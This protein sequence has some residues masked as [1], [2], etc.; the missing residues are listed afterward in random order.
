MDLFGDVLFEEESNN[1]F[2]FKTIEQAI[3]YYYI[4]PQFRISVLNPDESI[5][6]IIPNEDIPVDGINYTEEYQNGQRRNLTLKLLNDKG[7]YNPSING[8]WLT[9]KFKYDIGLRV[10]NKIL[11]FPKGTYV[12]GNVS[13]D[14]NEG[15][16]IVTLTLKDKYAIFEGKMGTLEDPYEVEVGSNIYDAVKGVM[17]FNAGNGHIFDYKPVIFDSSFVGAKTQ[18]TIR[19][20]EGG[21]V[22]QV[23]EA[24]ATQLSAEYYYNSVGNLCFYPTNVTINDSDKPVI[25]VFE[26]GNLNRELHNMSLNFQ[27]E[28]IVNVVK[29]VGDNVD[30]HISSAVVTNENPA[31]PICIQQIGRRAAPKYTDP[32]IWNDDLAHDLAMYYLKLHSFAA[33]DFSMNVSF[34][35]I[36]TV[37]N[38]CEVEDE[39]LKLKREKLLIKS[40]SYSSSE[41]SMSLNLCNTADLPFTL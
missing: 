36:L 30:K 31:S 9:T 6:Y 34:N 5:D 17:N 8:I 23:I 12:L 10:N 29:V 38:V 26:R 1:S 40:I 28:E 11:W 41:G 33:V 21:N 4:K 14:K 25:W 16:S 24:L 3:K 35:P 2:S 15:D 19:I 20:E 7:K 13:L 37:N 39:F 18:S 27:N 22:G 32:N